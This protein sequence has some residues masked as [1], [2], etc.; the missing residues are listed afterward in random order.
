MHVNYAICIAVVYKECRLLSS[1]SIFPSLKMLEGTSIGTEKHMSRSKLLSFAVFV[2]WN[3]GI[4]PC[5][6][7]RRQP[8]DAEF[9]FDWHPA[10]L[11]DIIKKYMCFQSN[12]IVL[13][14]G[15]P[16]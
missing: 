14:T 8:I 6:S 12:L 15:I 10:E 2:L 7:Q 11:N 16:E 13:T 9:E 3:T 4:S 1:S 5:E